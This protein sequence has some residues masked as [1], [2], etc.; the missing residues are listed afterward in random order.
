MDVCGYAQ[1]VSGKLC[2]VKLHG[3]E[4]ALH[5]LPHAH[6][7]GL[8]MPFTVRVHHKLDL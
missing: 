7:K 3:V 1:V 8:Y 2:G 6:V 5:A 4:E